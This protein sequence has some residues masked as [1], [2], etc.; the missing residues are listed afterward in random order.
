VAAFRLAMEPRA[1]FRSATDLRGKGDLLMEVLSAPAGR[2]KA[3]A[4][5][6]LPARLAALTRSAATDVWLAIR[7]KVWH[8]PAPL[9]HHAMVCYGQPLARHRDDRDKFR[10]A[11]LDEALPEGPRQ[12]IGAAATSAPMN[13]AARHPSPAAA[14]AARLPSP[15]LETGAATFVPSH[16]AIAWASSRVMRS[17]EPPA[18]CPRSYASNTMAGRRERR[19]SAERPPVR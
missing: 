4:C 17:S 2:V 12:R 11:G 14:N 16:S 13:S 8:E 1:S 9:R 10:L 15:V 7:S 6:L 3:S 5:P 19:L 18:F